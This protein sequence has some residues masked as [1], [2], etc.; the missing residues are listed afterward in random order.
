MSGFENFR[1]NSFEQLCI[2]VA[3]EHLQFYFNQHIFLQEEQ[4]YQLEGIEFK[5]VEFQNNE[6]L[7]ELFMGP[8][9]L[10][11]L[12]DEE[13]KFPKATDCSLINKFHSNFKFTQRYIRSKGNDVSF[14]ISHYAGRVIYNADG[15]LEKNRDNLS[16][17]LVDC[18]KQSKIKLISELFAAE[19]SKSGSI[20][21]SNSSIIARPNLLCRPKKSYYA[22]KQDIFLNKAKTL[23][24]SM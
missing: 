18:M 16:S 22:I 14:A 12:L 10:F 13:S 3:N 21:R 9:G 6:D 20:S 19:L 5:S 1:S 8:L 7:I 15:F 23:K 11:A 24:K 2:N 17:N 4:E